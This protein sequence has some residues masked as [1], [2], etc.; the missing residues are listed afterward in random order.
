MMH[1]AFSYTLVVAAFLLSA[2]TLTA[3]QEVEAR[4]LGGTSYKSSSSGDNCEYV[5]YGSG[6]DGKKGG[7]GG[8]KG[9]D[10]DCE[11]VCD[12][13]GYGSGSSHDYGYGSSSSSG[14]KK[15]GYS[16]GKK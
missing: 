13:Y 6:S 2:T 11:W 7:S 4:Q 12:D 1:K 10:D 8:K 3:A 16:G 9:S 14:G 5:C 15:G